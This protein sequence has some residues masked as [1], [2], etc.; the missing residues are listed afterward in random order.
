MIADLPVSLGISTHC[1]R[2]A[3]ANQPRARKS[4][5]HARSVELGAATSDPSAIA[6]KVVARPSGGGCQGKIERS[7]AAGISS[8]HIPPKIT[9]SEKFWV[10]KILACGDSGVAAGALFGSLAANHC[11]DRVRIDGHF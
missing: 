3:K 11:R 8:L 9:W 6:P 1:C 2:P 4:R 5:A 7:I 10:S